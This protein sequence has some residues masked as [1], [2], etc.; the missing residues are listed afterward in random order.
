M[1]EEIHCGLTTNGILPGGLNVQRVAQ[2]LYNRRH[3]DE[4]PETRENRIVCAYA[5]AAAE[6]NAS[7]GKIVTAP[8]CGACAVLPAVLKYMQEKKGFSDEK[9]I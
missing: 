9:I 8:T 7:G 6:H 5:F 3:I 2:L 4:S 1:K